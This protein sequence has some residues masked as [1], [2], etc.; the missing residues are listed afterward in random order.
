[1]LQPVRRRTWAPQGQTP[2]QIV[3]DRRDRISV[4]CA[5]SLSPRRRRLGLYFQ[6]QRRNIN[7]DDALSFLRQLLAQL[8]RKIILVLDRWSVHRSAARRLLARRSSR[9][10]VE[11]LPPYSP[12]LNP[13]EYLWGHTKSADMANYIADDIIDLHCEIELSLFKT[14]AQQDLLRSFFRQAKL[15]L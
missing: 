2:I 11:W 15:P 7:G 9:V 10:H 6:L 13:V 5:I 3:W 8:Q 1:M 12:E 4:S 14:E